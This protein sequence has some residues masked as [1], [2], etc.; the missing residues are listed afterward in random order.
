M[1]R[2]LTKENILLS[3]AALAGIIFVVANVYVYVK[4]HY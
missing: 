2:I 1:K 3:L 4:A